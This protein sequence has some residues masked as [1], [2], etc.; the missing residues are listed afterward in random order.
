MIITAFKLNNDQT[1]QL[2]KQIFRNH[3]APIRLYL[4][5]TT[6]VTRQSQL[7]NFYK[8]ILETASLKSN[9]VHVIPPANLSLQV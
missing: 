3:H 5:M 9:P 7:I 8:E 2:P 6:F 4:S 1:L